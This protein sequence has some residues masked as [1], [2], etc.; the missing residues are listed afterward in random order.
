MELFCC[1]NQIPGGSFGCN[2]EVGRERKMHFMSG[3]VLAVVKEGMYFH[4]P[5]DS[6]AAFSI[7]VD[8][9]HSERKIL[10][11][12][13]LSRCLHRN[14][15]I[16]VMGLILCCGDAFWS[17]IVFCFAQKCIFKSAKF[18]LFHFHSGLPLK[19]LFCCTSC[20]VTQTLYY[21]VNITSY[22]ALVLLGWSAFDLATWEGVKVH[23]QISMPPRNVFIAFGTS[24]LALSR[25]Q[26]FAD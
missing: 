26:T 15:S 4:L 12:G 13:K 24:R 23:L 18:G 16:Y 8:F 20:W 19:I 21:P 2:K 14:C 17:W 3:N 9:M 7:T 22:L 5:G 1:N 25:R 11:L 10:C 6:F